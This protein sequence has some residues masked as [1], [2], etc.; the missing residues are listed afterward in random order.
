MIYL[1][2]GLV[3]LILVILTYGMSFAYFQKEFSIL[4]EGAYRQDMAQSVLLALFSPIS[5][6]VVFFNTGFAEHGL[7]F[8]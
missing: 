7:K 3:W 2:I 5:T 8:K 1:I 6:I 4:S